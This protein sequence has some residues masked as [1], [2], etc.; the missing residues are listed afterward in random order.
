[1]KKGEVK[2]TG[3]QGDG[4]G[5]VEEEIEYDGSGNEYSVKRMS[6]DLLGRMVGLTD[7]DAGTNFYLYSVNGVTVPKYDK[8]W[9]TEY[10]DLGRK[11][12]I[13]YPETAP[14]RTDTKH[15]SYNDLENSVSVIDPSN[16][17]TYE[18]RD[19]N[20]NLTQT[21]RYG[22]SETKNEEI[23]EINNSYDKLNRLVKTVDP[24]GLVITYRYDERNLLLNENYG[25]TGSDL[26]DLRSGLVREKDRS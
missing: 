3:Q 24:N 16:R 26:V 13:T 10:D 14:G 7:P 17:K 22:V 15:F 23:Q 5:H 19:W 4:L 1:M 21:V 8:T 25:T 11:K 6:Y 12:W 9:I 18:K 2:V 20:N